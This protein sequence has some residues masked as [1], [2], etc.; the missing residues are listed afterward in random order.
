MSSSGS[1][2]FKVQG[3]IKW[4]PKGGVASNINDKEELMEVEEQ[5]PRRLITYS[6][7]PEPM[8]VN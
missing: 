5:G 8:N 4:V 1:F 6:N 2:N 3:T 7:G